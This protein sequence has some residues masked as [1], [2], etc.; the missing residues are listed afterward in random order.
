MAAYGRNIEGH[1]I[2]DKI[3]CTAPKLPKLA[4]S[5]LKDMRYVILFF[6]FIFRRCQSAD[7]V[8]L[9]AKH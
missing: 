4:P 9:S 8:R 5:N 3:H 2:E 6:I 7:K 1:N